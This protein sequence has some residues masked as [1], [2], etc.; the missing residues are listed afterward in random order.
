MLYYL[1]GNGRNNCTKVCRLNFQ[2]PPYT[3]VPIFII[4][5][6]QIITQAVVKCARKLCTEI[7]RSNNVQIRRSFVVSLDFPFNKRLPLLCA[8]L[9]SRNYNFLSFKFRSSQGSRNLNRLKELQSRG[10]IQT[11]LFIFFYHMFLRN[12]NSNDVAKQN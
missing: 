1:V 8:R 7:A 5:I 4:S 6:S 9:F 11:F 10:W 2:R 12:R 3:A